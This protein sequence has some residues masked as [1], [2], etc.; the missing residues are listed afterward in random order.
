MAAISDFNALFTSLCRA[1]SVFFSNSGD[2]MIALNACPH[3]PDMS[4]IETYVAPMVDLS[5]SLSES[6][7]MPEDAAVSAAAVSV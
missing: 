2:T 5:F 3:P 4:S 1:R 7:V 6:G